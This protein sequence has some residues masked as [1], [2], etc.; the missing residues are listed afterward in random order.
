ME[1]PLLQR[2]IYE[3]TRPVVPVS[4]QFCSAVVNDV[5]RNITR[6]LIFAKLAGIVDNPLQPRVPRYDPTPLAVDQHGTNFS[7]GGSLDDCRIGFVKGV[8]GC[9]KIFLSADQFL[10]RD[11]AVAAINGDRRG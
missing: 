2:V 10:H 8:V 9:Q 6:R 3:V 7:I 1:S 5:E 4:L 11:I